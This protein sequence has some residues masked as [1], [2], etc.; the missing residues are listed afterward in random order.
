MTIDYDVVIIGGSL[1]AYQAALTATQLRATVALVESE[2]NYDF[3][4]HLALEEIGK[5]VGRSGN[6]KSNLD[7]VILYARTIADNVAQINSLSNLAAQG[8]DVIVGGGEFLPSR[9]LAFG[10][11]G[12]LLRSR[13]YLLA[14]G[15]RPAIPKIDG[16]ESTGY[17]TLSN[18]GEILV[19][20][21]LPENW[22]ILGG[23]P[24]S[25]EISQL[26][27]RLGC[28]VTLIVQQSNVFRYLDREIGE[29]LLGQLEA[30]G[31][32]VVTQRPVTQTRCIEGKKW[33][34]VGDKAIETDE[35]LVATGH[36]PNIEL[37]NLAAAGVKWQR[38]HLVVNDKLQT[39]NERIY[40][41]GDVIG[42]Y[43]ILS[44]GN[45]EAN[46]AV[47]NALFFSRL[48][49]NYRCIP[50]GI[51]SQPMVAQVG[52]T[53]IQARGRYGKN[54]V[55]VL[56]KYFKTSI[57][58]QVQGEITGICKLIVL[59]NGEILGASILGQEAQ[60]LINLVALIMSKNIKVESLGDLAVMYPS[61]SDILVQTAR[62]WGKQRLN[63]NHFLQDFLE[64]FFDFRRDWNL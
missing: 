17:F 63:R 9:Q 61:F 27:R 40:A 8:V 18:I 19:K 62:E 39:T 34:Q 54:K 44:I 12:R 45:Y 41:C 2:S 32:R 26:L 7:E 33:I 52:L 10:V 36:Q 22:V 16:I 42:G 35:I 24:Q 15:S 28:Y 38:G 55:L 13:T 5:M 43:D 4:Y 14:C 59:E 29:L 46:I 48:L 51:N 49:V 6:V 58:A 25:V 3:N 20:T 37:L 57:A 21:N 64:G 47:K 60:E 30:D 56:R 53:E 23:V 31:V 50:W 11:N 1:A